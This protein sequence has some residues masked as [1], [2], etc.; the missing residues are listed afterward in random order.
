MSTGIKKKYFSNGKNSKSFKKEKKTL[1]PLKSVVNDLPESVVN[2]LP[3][4]VVNDSP[5]SVVNDSPESVV[6]DSPES[7]VND[8]PESVVNDLS[9]IKD[10]F[11]LLNKDHDKESKLQAKED[12]KK[13]FY[14]E[15]KRKN[16]IRS[17]SGNPRFSCLTKSEIV[18][19]TDKNL[20][21]LKRKMNTDNGIKHS[22][23]TS[24]VEE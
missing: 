12:R 4:S 7:V 11:E 6:N 19:K 9:E 1:G 22:C 24:L 3:E 13:N 17:L 10:E 14:L 20:K 2:D 23:S 15:K 16:E 5:E 21:K 8:S 18:R